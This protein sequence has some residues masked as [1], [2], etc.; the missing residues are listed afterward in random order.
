MLEV[1]GPIYLEEYD[2]TVDEHNAFDVTEANTRVVYE[3]EGDRKKEFIAVLADEV[4]QRV[5]HPAPGTWSPLIDMVQQLGDERDLQIYSYNPELQSVIREFGWDGEVEHVE[6]NDFLM[7]V[8]ASV[9]STKLNAVLEQDVEVEVRLDANGNAT[10]TVAVDYFNDLATWEQ[11]RDPD[12]VEKLMLGGLYGGYLRLY[13]APESTITSVKYAEREVGLEEVSRENGLRVFGR[14][15]D[16]PRDQREQIVFTYETP[17]AARFEGAALRYAIDIAK[18]SGT[19]ID[20]FHIRV[21][22]P[23]G[24]EMTAATLDGDPVRAETIAGIDVDLTRDRTLS[25]TFE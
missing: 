14:F 5:L 17:G 1:T 19:G 13:V 2:L 23:D 3:R 22:G 20:E 9:H 10:T 7:L 24:M 8:D 18:Q 16:L 15:F 12:L 6:G 25:F 11:G 4:L 21:I